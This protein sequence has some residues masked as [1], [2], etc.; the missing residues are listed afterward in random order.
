[1]AGPI[2]KLEDNIPE[3][4]ELVCAELEGV[5]PKG[6]TISAIEAQVLEDLDGERYIRLLV[7][8]PDN[9]PR[10]DANVANQFSVDL[11]VACESR[12]LPY[13]M[14]AYTRRPGAPGPDPADRPRRTPMAG[15]IHGIAET[16]P[17][18]KDLVRTELEGV[19][20]RTSGES[21]L[22]EDMEAEVLEDQDGNE[23]IRLVVFLPEDSPMP[24]PR[25]A[26][27]FS[28]DLRATCSNHGLQHPTVVYTKR[29]GNRA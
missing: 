18:I 26:N 16:I 20:P 23:Y 6:S 4:K 17:D 28:V 12:G 22:I 5:L 1:M 10:I 29:A 27:Q 7:I 19:L 8:M 2:R 15:P 9:R 14:V 13:P 25:V 24:D 3:L 21:P 11:R